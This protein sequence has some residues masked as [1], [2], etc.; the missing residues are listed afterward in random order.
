MLAA[1]S[2]E[3]DGTVVVNVS[4]IKEVKGRLVVSFFDS[5]K[6]FMKLPV[7]QVAIPVTKTGA[8]TVRC[9]G[10]PAGVYGLTVHQDF[11][12]DNKIEKNALGIPTEPFGFGNNAMGRMG[13]PSFQQASITVKAGGELDTAVKLVGE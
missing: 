11:D 1:V 4:D 2:G 9:E 10:V 3:E 7:K 13:P 12:G 6:E 5:E 8:E